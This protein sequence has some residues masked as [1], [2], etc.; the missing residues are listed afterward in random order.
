M[1]YRD[2]GKMYSHEIVVVKRKAAIFWFMMGCI[3][4]V[5]TMIIIVALVTRG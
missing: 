3:C 5:I 1:S 4:T 2:L